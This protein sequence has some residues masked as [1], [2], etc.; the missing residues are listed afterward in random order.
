M[1]RE[2]EAERQEQT[3]TD[4]KGPETETDGQR[5][6]G[7][8]SQTDRGTETETDNHRQA[9]AERQDHRDGQ[10]DTQTDKGTRETVTQR[11]VDRQGQTVTDTQGQTQR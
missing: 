4:R 11:W 5:D 9:G 3:V 7:R 6:K 2:A 1:D 10:T 8:Q